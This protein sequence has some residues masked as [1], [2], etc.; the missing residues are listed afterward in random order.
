MR[1]D[2]LL[3][4]A[5]RGMKNEKLKIK[6]WYVIPSLTKD[7]L[8]RKLLSPFVEFRVTINFHF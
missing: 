1:A 7:Y 5:L 2:W 8:I 6:N 3:F 4:T